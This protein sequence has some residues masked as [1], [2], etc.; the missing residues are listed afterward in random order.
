[1]KIAIC[2]SLDFIGEMKK[3]S[4][5]LL[6]LGHQTVL[7][8]SAEM[9]IGGEVTTDVIRKE[10]ESGRAA[11]RKIMLDAIKRHYDKIADSD[12]ILVLNYTKKDIE[13]YIGGNTFLEIGFAH[14]L[15][16]KIFLLN[17]IP[18]MPYTDEILAMQP[19]VIHGDMALIS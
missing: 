1:M 10:N 19:K 14:V 18:I 17:S 9:V 7:P 11:E 8:K 5:Q 15:G 3:V 4:D 13:N 16:K 2:G 6:M 12:A